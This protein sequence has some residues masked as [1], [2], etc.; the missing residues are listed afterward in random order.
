MR[1]PAFVALPLLALVV[2]AGCAKTAVTARQSYE[3]PRLA[4]PD[5]IIV[6]VRFREC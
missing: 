6:R 5:R 4:R 2:A 1:S 3:G